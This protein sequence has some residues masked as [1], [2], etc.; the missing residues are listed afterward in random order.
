MGSTVDNNPYGLKLFITMIEEK[1][2]LIPSHTWL[3]F[4]GEGWENS[5]YTTVTWRQYLNGINKVAHWLDETLGKSSDND[6]VA[7]AGPNDIRYAL[8]W[9]AVV[10]TG[11]KAST[12]KPIVSCVFQTDIFSSCWSVTA[13]SLERV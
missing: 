5:G 2:A 12:N 3:R 4:P 8:I 9:A 6:T 11:R 13:G 1:A 7:Y 10:K